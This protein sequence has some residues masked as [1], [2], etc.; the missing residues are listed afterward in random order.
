MVY[1]WNTARTRALNN[2]K[3]NNSDNNNNNNNN[4]DNNNN[5]NNGLYSSWDKNTY[6]ILQRKALL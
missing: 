1:D 5:N 6:S 3:I 2:N 4:N